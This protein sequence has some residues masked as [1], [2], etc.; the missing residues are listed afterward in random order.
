[1]GC[2]PVI[3]PAALSLQVINIFG[4]RSKLTGREMLHGIGNGPSI[5]ASDISHDAIDV[6]NHESL[7]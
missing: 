4:T 2:F 3:I 1:L 6:E 7:G 5:G